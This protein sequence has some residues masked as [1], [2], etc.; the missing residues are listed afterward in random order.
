MIKTK[1]FKYPQGQRRQHFMATIHT[2][3]GNK[4]NLCL[5]TEILTQILTL[6]VSVNIE[7]H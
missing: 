2:Y 7:N 1:Y 4:K 3:T 6:V 5:E